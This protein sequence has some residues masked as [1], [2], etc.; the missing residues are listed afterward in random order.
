VCTCIVSL[1]LKEF[2]TSRVVTELAMGAVSMGGRARNVARCHVQRR[3]PA[4]ERHQMTPSRPQIRG[5]TRACSE[6]H[7]VLRTAATLYGG[8]SL[9]HCL[10]GDTLRARSHMFGAKP[11][12]CVHM[13]PS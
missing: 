9:I 5:I 11:C 4:T 6:R 3:H 1:A 2:E 13:W 8:N 7:F 10:S 12:V